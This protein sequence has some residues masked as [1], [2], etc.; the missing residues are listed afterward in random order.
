MKITVIGTGHI[1]G[2]LAKKLRAAGHDIRVANAM[3]GEELKRFA[4][5]IGAIPADSVAEAVQGAEVVIL[6]IPVN[7]IVDLKPVLTALPPSTIL[8]DTSNYFPH[9]DK[10]IIQPLE[11][12]SIAE[13]QWVA[14]Q[15]GRPVVKAWNAQLAGTLAN[16]GLLPHSPNRIAIPIAGDDESAVEI[17]GKLVSD[18]G[19]D[20]VFSG[21][22]A[23]SWR[24]QP[25]TPAYCGDYSAEEVRAKL[26]LA[27]R[28]K[29][30]K[31]RDY[32]LQKLAEYVESKN[33]VFDQFSEEDHAFLLKTNRETAEMDV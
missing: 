20:Y 3:G 17:V 5:S 32:L 27:E 14:E 28:Q 21:S 19:F 2:N 8:V 16:K 25:G 6:S 7:A 10:V 13:S 30:P 9:R 22:L 23:D 18:T 15:L 1:G 33:G 12:L 4:E 31:R 24:Q 29:S 26:D 11:D